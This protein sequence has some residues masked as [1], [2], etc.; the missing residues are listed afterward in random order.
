[1]TLIPHLHLHTL[2]GRLIKQVTTIKWRIQYQALERFH[3]RDSYVA[4][5]RLKVPA[6]EVRNNHIFSDAL[7]LV[8][9]NSVAYNQGKLGASATSGSD[10]EVPLYWQNRNNLPPISGG[11]EHRSTVLV[12]LHHD[13]TGRVLD[14]VSP[15]CPADVVNGTTGAVA[16]ANWLPKVGRQH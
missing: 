8:N 12:K 2:R 6:G 4:E 9:G 10:E 11:Q 15:R 13:N 7:R 3:T 16:E 14:G 5:T 1:M